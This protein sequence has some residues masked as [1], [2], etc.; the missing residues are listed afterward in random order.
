MKGLLFNAVPQDSM[1][2][3]AVRRIAYR[4]AVPFLESHISHRNATHGFLN[5]HNEQS[6][7]PSLTITR[8]RLALESKSLI[9]KCLHD[10]L[11][12]FDL[13]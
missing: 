11:H 1:S 7:V 9:M 8:D 4:V 5:V 6:H 10:C 12:T 2:S 13:S 3:T